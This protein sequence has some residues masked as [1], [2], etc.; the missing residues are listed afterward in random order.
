MTEKRRPPVAAKPSF[1]QNVSSAESTP[2]PSPALRGATLA[3]AVKKPQSTAT[4]ASHNPSTGALLAATGAF[5]KKPQPPHDVAVVPLQSQTIRGRPLTADGLPTAITEHASLS[6]HRLAIRPAAPRS[7]SAVAAVAA[8]AST[9]PVRRPDLRRAQDSYQRRRDDSQTRHQSL[10]PN[11]ETEA[12]R[13]LHQSA[14][15]LAGAKASVKAAPI[16]VPTATGEKPRNNLS[17][18]AVLTA[19]SVAPSSATSPSFSGTTAAATASR[20]AAINQARARAL[21]TSQETSP[22]APVNRYLDASP[23][24]FHDLQES[25]SS[26]P[27]EP[28]T[29]TRDFFASRTYKPLPAP[30]PVRAH[31]PALAAQS[32]ST[33]PSTPILDARTRLTASSLADAMVA[34]SVAAQLTGSRASPQSTKGPAPPVPPKRSKSVGPLEHRRHHLMHLPGMRSD[35]MHQAPKHKPLEQRP[36]RQTLRSSTEK[37]EPVDEKR[38]RKHWRRHPN[39]HH[40]GDRKRWRDKVT[41]LERKRYEGVWAANRGLLL[42]Q[43]LVNLEDLDPRKDG[44]PITDL[45]VNVVVRDI[46]ERSRLPKDVLEEVW[47]LV[48]PPGSKSLSRY[49]FVVGLW[50]IDQRLKGR[51]LPVKVS[52]SVWASV[53]HNIKISSK[54]IPR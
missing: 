9:S 36:F 17:Y 48:A 14:A 23:Q 39:M 20:T 3:A 24:S 26:L 37:E 13:A 34:G 22:D 50:L 35:A 46:W 2:L 7:T 47:D 38:G 6:P 8:S 30:I 45:V 18:L 42:D 49:E 43:D 15:A 11:Q 27:E 12:I 5:S 28:E 33:S 54:P 4:P 53:R 44:T 40:E 10:R 25:P 1:V 16:Q 29:Q 41:E 21:S 19:P 31:R 32:T 52:P 51:K